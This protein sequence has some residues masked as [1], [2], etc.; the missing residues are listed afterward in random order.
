MSKEIISHYVCLGQGCSSVGAASD[1]HVADEGSIL[2][3]GKGFSFQSQLSVQ[4]LL[5]RPYTPVCS[6]MR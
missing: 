6:R 2:W 4:T 3:C 5:R 1:W